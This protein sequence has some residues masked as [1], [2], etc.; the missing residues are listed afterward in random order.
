M[1]IDQ[2]FCSCLHLA[3]VWYPFRSCRHLYLHD[4]AIGGEQPRTISIS[5]MT[6]SW[7]PACSRRLRHD[8]DVVGDAVISVS[9]NDNTSGLPGSSPTC[10]TPI[11]DDDVR[12]ASEQRGAIYTSG[13]RLPGSSPTHPIPL[14][15]HY[16]G[17]RRVTYAFY[18]FRNDIVAAA[19]VSTTRTMWGCR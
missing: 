10:S 1:L 5:A 14:R 11:R 16:R 8:D 15:C 2:F 13:M 12:A 18:N 4:D 19:V 17:C 3:W 7:L 6:S 9:L